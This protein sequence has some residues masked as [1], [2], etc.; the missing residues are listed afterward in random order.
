MQYSPFITGCDKSGGCAGCIC[1]MFTCLQLP[2]HLRFH[3][4]PFCSTGSAPDV[5]L[6]LAA[7]RWIT[8]CKGYTLALNRPHNVCLYRQA[9]PATP[10]TPPLLPLRPAAWLHVRLTT[11]RL[12]RPLHCANG[13][14]HVTIRFHTLCDPCTLPTI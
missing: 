9:A 3:V 13:C 6:S 10:H 7:F 14:A 4:V 1:H 5:L 8:V 11:G 12:S 2:P